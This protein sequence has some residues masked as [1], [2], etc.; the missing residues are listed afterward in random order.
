MPKIALYS[1]PILG[2]V[3]LASCLEPC[4]LCC[5]LQPGA[6]CTSSACPG[7]SRCDLQLPSPAEDL[8]AIPL[9]LPCLS[10]NALKFA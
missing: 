7:R 1:V 9:V 10:R 6:S 2:R 4:R 5:R 3:S 8:T